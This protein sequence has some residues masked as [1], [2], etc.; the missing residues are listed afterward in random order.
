MAIVQNLSCEIEKLMGIYPNV[1][2]LECNSDTQ[3]E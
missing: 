3:E 1:P 2:K